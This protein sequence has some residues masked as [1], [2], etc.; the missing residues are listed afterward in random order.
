M[1]QST[2]AILFYGYCWDDEES[3]PWLIGREYTDYEGTVDELE[4]WEDRLARLTG[5]KEPD[6]KFPDGKRDPKTY[7]T[8]YTPE[9]QK[10]VD[11]Y[12]AYW[13]VKRDAVAK[14]GVQ[15]AW[16]C[17]CDCSMPYVCVTKSKITCH[18]GDM[19]EIKGLEIGKNWN[20]KLKSF[21]ELMGIDV[22]DQKPKWWMVSMWC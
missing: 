16:H 17:S 21:C 4:D 18:R 22:K 1:G 19:Q 20:T 8:V 9:E 10:I 7:Q 2:N 15:V 6:V 14:F 11:L 12:S 3:K 5:L 13:K